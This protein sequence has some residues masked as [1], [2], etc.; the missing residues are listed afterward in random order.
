M[1][2]QKRVEEISNCLSSA[3]ESCS[4]LAAK[5]PNEVDVA[6]IG[7]WSKS[8]YVALTL[9]AALGYRQEEMVRHSANALEQ[10]QRSVGIVLARGAL[11]NAALIW[12][13]LLTL[14]A[15]ATYTPQALHEALTKMLMGN[16]LPGNP[17]DGPVAH[18]ILSLL[19]KMNR[20]FPGVRSMYDELSE[21]AHPNYGGVHGLYAQTQYEEFRTLFGIE[22]RGSSYTLIAAKGL[23]ASIGVFNYALDEIDTIV[24][25]WIPTLSP[26]TG[27]RDPD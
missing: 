27:P 22:L 15:R 17:T 7:V 12:S 6:T 19:D 10:N 5:L 11:E 16:K 13:L 25:A 18:N 24:E 1:S 23:A 20:K 4:L 9:R 21:I 8:P 3:R 26:L 2:T 14:Q